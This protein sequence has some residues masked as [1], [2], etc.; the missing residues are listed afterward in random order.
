MLN[1]MKT[2]QSSYFPPENVARSVKSTNGDN[3]EFTM[4]LKPGVNPNSNGPVFKGFGYSYG[5]ILFCLAFKWVGLLEF[6]FIQNPD[7]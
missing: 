6:R 3:N 1:M 4:T 5:P 7:Q 2:I